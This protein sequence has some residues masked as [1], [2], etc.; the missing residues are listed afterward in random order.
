MNSVGIDIGLKFSVMDEMLQ[1]W[2]ERKQAKWKLETKED[3]ERSGRTEQQ[4]GNVR[5][6][7]EMS[8]G[9]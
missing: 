8:G 3:T 9:R 2:M 6:E 1:G 5:E 4:D 7:E